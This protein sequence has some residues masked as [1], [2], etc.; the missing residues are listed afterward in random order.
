MSSANTAATNLMF[1][2]QYILDI[3]NDSTGHDDLTDNAR[4]GE[5][6]MFFK[7]MLSESVTPKSSTSTPSTSSS[8]MNKSF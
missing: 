2:R 4:E 6:I 3:L 8:G 1:N 5:G 7:K